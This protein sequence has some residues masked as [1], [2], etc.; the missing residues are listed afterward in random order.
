MAAPAND[1]KARRKAA[2][3][4]HFAITEANKKRRILKQA[5]KFPNDKQAAAKAAAL[6][7]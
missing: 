3:A 5:R 6:S 7:V 1:S 4:A 2:Y